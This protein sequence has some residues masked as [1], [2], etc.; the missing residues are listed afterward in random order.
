MKLITEAA[1]P[2]PLQQRIDDARKEG[3]LWA[4]I[5]R[6]LNASGAGAFT[7][8]TAQRSYGPGA[9]VNRARSR[10]RARK[11][12]GTHALPGLSVADAALMLDL[13]PH[14]LRRRIAALPADST[15]VQVVTRGK[16]QQVVRVTD[17]GAL[18]VGSNR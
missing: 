3:V 4:D 2:G 17:L 13:D 11:Q 1:T 10:A 18:D 16:M 8:Q 5:A 15:A 14:T 9:D 6:A 7:P 12:R